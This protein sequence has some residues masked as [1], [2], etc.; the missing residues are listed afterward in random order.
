MNQKHIAMT[1]SL[2]G[3]ESLKSKAFAG[4]WLLLK[5]NYGF[6]LANDLFITLKV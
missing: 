4:L 2:G 1:K 3:D 6:Y 5:S